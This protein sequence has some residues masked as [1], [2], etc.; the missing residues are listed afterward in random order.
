MIIAP[1]SLSMPPVVLII[2]LGNKEGFL[3][4]GLLMEVCLCSQVSSYPLCGYEFDVR[5]YRIII[6]KLVNGD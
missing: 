4:T 1:P 5:E 3:M 6:L 2:A